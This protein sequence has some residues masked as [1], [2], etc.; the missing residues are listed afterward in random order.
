MAPPSD[1]TT[2]AV[3]ACICNIVRYKYGVHDTGA[4]FSYAK[5]LKWT[6]L[7]DNLRR[8]PFPFSSVPEIGLHVAG[9]VCAA[10]GVHAFPIDMAGLLFVSMTIGNNSRVGNSIGAAEF[11]TR[12]WLRFMYQ[13]DALGFRVKR[14]ATQ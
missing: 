12:V 7:E 14:C 5:L 13:F 9:N 11:S 6:A 3:G 4:L 2:L 8:Q 10:A 1:S